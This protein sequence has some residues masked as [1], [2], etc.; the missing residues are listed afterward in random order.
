MRVVSRGVKSLRIACCDVR[1]ID[2][3]GH[4]VDPRCIIIPA[5]PPVN[6][7]RHMNEVSGS[8]NQ[9]HQP[10][11]CRFSAPRIIRG[12]NRMDVEMDG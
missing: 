5:N 10:V 9:C 8:R 7:G 4:D 6:V 11:C 3:G 2:F 1:F 12:L